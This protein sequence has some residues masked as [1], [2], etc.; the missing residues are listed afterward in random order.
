MNIIILEDNKNHREQLIGLLNEWSLSSNHKLTILSYASVE[1][2]WSYH[3]K[4]QLTETDLFLL[5]I[6]INT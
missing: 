1:D 3:T 2:F 5:D 6:K 4:D